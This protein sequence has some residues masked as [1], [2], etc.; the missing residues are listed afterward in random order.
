MYCL[1][2]RI[3]CAG[4]QHCPKPDAA[5]PRQVDAVVGQNEVS[6]LLVSVLLAL[7]GVT[8]QE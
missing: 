8:V 2:M 7:Y 1:T 4:N 5:N 6:R 3:T